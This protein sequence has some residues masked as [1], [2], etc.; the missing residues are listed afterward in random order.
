MI[1]NA[2]SPAKSSPMSTAYTGPTQPIPKKSLQIRTDKPRPHVCS[3]C[4]RGFARL[5]H[6]KRHER[7]HTNEKPFQCAACGRCFARRDLVLRHQQKLHLHI[8]PI[9]R[10]DSASGAPD[11][12][13]SSPQSDHIIILHN[14]TN[15]KAPLPPDGS[16]RGLVLFTPHRNSTLAILSPS[17]AS[18]SP[19]GYPLH[20]EMPKHG[21]IDFRQSFSY[22][23]LLGATA[24]KLP[25]PR[26][27]SSHNTPTAHGAKTL[28]HDGPMD[29]TG[30]RSMMEMD[31]TQEPSPLTG[32]SPDVKEK[33][34]PIPTWAT[35]ATSDDTHQNHRHASFSAVS[36]VSYTNLKDALYIQSH[37]IPDGPTHVGFATPQLTAA[38]I[39]SKG[40]QL[41]DFGSL[42]L[43][44]Y[45]STLH[46]SQ[47][48]GHAQQPHKPAS[49][50]P[51]LDTI[52]S[53][54]NLLAHGDSQSS[55]FTNSIM[56]AHRFQDPQHPHHIPGTTPLDFAFPSASNLPLLFHEEGK[57]FSNNGAVIAEM[58]GDLAT[59]DKDIQR[60]RPGKGKKRLLGSPNAGPDSKKPNV[61]FVNE[62][63]DL[64]WVNEFKSIPLNNEFPSASHDTG[65]LA[66]PHI[67]DQF[68]PDEVVSLFK[69]RQDDLVKE[70]SQI[71]LTTLSPQ[72]SEV[73][74]SSTSRL[75]RAKFTIGEASDFITEELRDKIVLASNVAD[76]QFP[77][78]ED[79]NSYINL[80]E[81]E[82]NTYFP[83]IH[84]PTLRNPMVDNFENI[85]LILSMCAIG[86]LYSYHDNN[87][88]LLF[89][90]SKYHIYNFF[91]KEVTVDKLQFKKVPIMAH[92]CLVLHI[93]ISM[94]LD[95]PNLTEITMRQMASMVGLIKSTN[96]HRP[97][98]LFL[99]PPPA[100][101]NPNEADVIQN[102]FDYFIMVQTRIR[103]IQTFYQLE[104]LR[105]SFLGTHL[106]MKGLDILSGSPCNDEQLWNASKA[107]E[108]YELYKK[109]DNAPLLVVANNVSMEA[110][111]E[112]L[113]SGCHTRGSA[114]L[115]KSMSMLMIVH[116][117][118]LGSYLVQ[119]AIG[120]PFDSLDWRVNQ[121][122][123]LE[124]LLKLWETSFI[125]NGGFSS[126]NENNAALLNNSNQL[127]L[128]FPLFSLAK[129]RICL[130][131]SPV[132]EKVFY[133]DWRGMS[134]TL[135]FWTTDVE[136]LK[137]ACVPSIEILKLW[138][139]NVSAMNDSRRF[140][141]RTPVYF[142]T[143][144]FIALTVLSKALVCLEESE[145]LSTADKALW[146]N[147]EK[148]FVKI[149]AV[150]CPSN[151]SRASSIPLRNQSQSSKLFEYAQST[152]LKQNVD[153]VISTLGNGSL[154]K[155]IASV[156]KCRLLTLSLCLGVR[157]LA[158]APLWPVALGFAE[159]L[160]YLATAYEE[161][162][163]HWN[164]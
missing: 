6:L 131:I 160:K 130:N 162:C 88:L 104:V 90:L 29:H 89:N 52:P 32:E 49:L 73:L 50:K 95:E 59:I 96:F 150:L 147:A 18:M 72:N 83:F 65:F 105:G 30:S 103:T 158:D 24:D 54:T 159:G 140:S 67:A 137:E 15:A 48:S 76:N 37:Q 148:L 114:T 68:E 56:A 146:M 41:V 11:D 142:V 115:N 61:G 74:S 28:G 157:V 25:S 1:A 79:L 45:G 8:G 9:V 70:R 40:L 81:A 55:Y 141:V 100:I 35:V 13:V 112:E 66:M 51:K 57:D 43:D 117:K 14:N 144:V 85:P 17:H 2:A 124:N 31:F 12:S 107:S 139:H 149:E 152:K 46:D 164:P 108:W 120:A 23:Q 128:L 135:N 33:K 71:N 26:T 155:C 129:I 38:E 63:C 97:L 80:Y 42:D 84:I 123:K 19:Q 119:K 136:A 125:I 21:G 127:K 111:S 138:V 109:Y 145:Y 60:T 110:L 20:H 94:F 143:C 153:S 98:E 36:S 4:T 161:D 78:L 5:E 27:S 133:K 86:A 7:S 116:E 118:I 92:Q 101:K 132:M 91:D 134:E 122:P 106:P 154:L 156:K 99:V 87:T 58:A 69:L 113:E 82:F 47:K 22:A 126:V 39:D 44:W 102:N 77:P 121:R 10:A 163:K 16:A 62:I 34:N 64:D 3:I 93:F 151:E 75:T 53:E